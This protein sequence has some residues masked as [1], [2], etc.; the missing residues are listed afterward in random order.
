M[1][2]TTRIKEEEEVRIGQTR[3]TGSAGRPLVCYRPK[4]SFFLSIYSPPLLVMLG[5]EVWVTAADIKE[6]YIWNGGNPRLAL[7]CKP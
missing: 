1:E 6:V 5:D 2:S 4:S 7:L 3:V